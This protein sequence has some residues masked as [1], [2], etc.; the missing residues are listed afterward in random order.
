L[1]SEETVAK[2]WANALAPLAAAFLC[3]KKRKLLKKRMNTLVGSS[4]LRYNNAT[5][6]GGISVIWGSMKNL[7][8]KS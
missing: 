7:S 6:G 1:A 4:F 3:Q 5:T 2:P 8:K